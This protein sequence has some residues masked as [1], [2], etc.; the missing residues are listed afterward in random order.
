MLLVGTVIGENEPTATQAASDPVVSFD[1]V[2]FQKKYEISDDDLS[3]LYHATDSP[4]R[5][6]PSSSTPTYS[7]TN[8]QVEFHLS[9]T[10]CGGGPKVLNDGNI[11]SVYLGSIRD[12]NN[13]PG[14]IGVNRNSKQTTVLT[15]GNLHALNY[16]VTSCMFSLEAQYAFERVSKVWID[17]NGNGVYE[18]PSELVHQAMNPPVPITA[19]NVVQFTVPEDAFKGSVG[20]RVA[21]KEGH[22]LNPCEHF[23]YGG[24]KEFEV[25]IVGPS[26]VDT[27]STL[28]VRNAA[29]VQTEVPIFVIGEY[30]EYSLDALFETCENLAENNT[31]LLG[32][33]DSITVNFKK[34]LISGV[35]VPEPL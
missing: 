16:R 3:K 12:S 29:Y 6:T 27:H 28:S 2:A 20:M 31:T 25:V 17:Y 18:E 15:V 24:I 4:T 30:F 7:T 35:P 5:S 10:Y 14:F 33:S 8:Q 23:T 11:G 19:S 26:I 32:L 34:R 21:V 13:C 22:E 1:W 9:Q